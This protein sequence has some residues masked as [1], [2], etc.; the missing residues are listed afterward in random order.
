MV[1][2]LPS[3]W[4]YVLRRAVDGELYVGQTTDLERRM[5]EHDKGEVP[6]T[7][8]RRPLELIYVEGHAHRADMVRRERYLKTSKGHRALKLMLPDALAKRG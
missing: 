5:T 3:Y 1:M 4:V 2:Q 8:H 7:R 6:S